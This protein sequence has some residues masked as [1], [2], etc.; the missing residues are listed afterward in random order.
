MRKRVDELPLRDWGK[1]L[2]AW[3]I[4]TSKKFNGTKS[5]KK[6]SPRTIIRCFSLPLPV[7]RGSSLFLDY[8]FEVK[9]K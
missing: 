8:G 4:L 6:G 3:D 2:I 9:S 5:L 1:K 7:G